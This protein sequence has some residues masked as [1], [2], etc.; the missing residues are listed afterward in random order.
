MLLA[1]HHLR[2]KD[3]YKL[4]VRAWKKT[5]HP[6]GNDRNM[7]VAILISDKIDIKNKGHRE[8]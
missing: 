5:F 4:K 6:N 7:G 2:A 3:T 1:R 8:R